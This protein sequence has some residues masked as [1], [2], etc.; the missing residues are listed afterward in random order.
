MAKRRIEETKLSQIHSDGGNG[1]GKKSADPSWKSGAR[2]NRS[3]GKTSFFLAS[4]SA[5]KLYSLRLSLFVIIESC[6]YTKG[7]AFPKKKKKKKERRSLSLWSF[8]DR[9]RKSGQRRTLQ[10]FEV[11]LDVAN[12]G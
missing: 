5:K 4:V 9:R 7:Y 2:T 11:S 3:S 8:A 6:R 10:P 1:M 12:E